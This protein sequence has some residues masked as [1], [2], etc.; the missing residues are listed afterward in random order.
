MNRK[1]FAKKYKTEI[2]LISREKDV[3]MGVATDML[4]AHVK[5]RNIETPYKYDFV[6]CENLDYALMDKEIKEM[7][8]AAVKLRG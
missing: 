4:I 6:G 1:E 5:N 7:E 8:D 2:S 3:D